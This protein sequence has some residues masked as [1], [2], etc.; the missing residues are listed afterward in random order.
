VNKG[1]DV[2][3]IA[4]GGF[5]SAGAGNATNTPTQRF[6]RMNIST[7]RIRDRD[8]SRADGLA[9]TLQDPTAEQ[10]EICIEAE[11]CFWCGA[12]HGVYGKPITGWSMHWSKAHGITAQSV[13]DILG[14]TTRRVFVADST[15]EKMRANYL[16]RDPEQIEEARQISSR[17]R[18]GKR[19]TLTKGGRAKLQRTMRATAR[20]LWHEEPELMEQAT[21]KRRATTLSKTPRMPCTVC[22]KPTKSPATAD[23]ATVRQSCSAACQA[24]LLRRRRVVSD[25]DVPEIRRRVD[26]GERHRDIAADFGC[27][28]RLISKIGQRE[29]R[30]HVPEELAHRSIY[31]TGELHLGPLNE[32]RHCRPTRSNTDDE[33]I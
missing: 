20:R 9:A 21:E 2:L 24:E 12:T 19:S 14:C 10:L 5:G 4:R 28:R 6:G 26:A 31:V 33:I 18:K 27:S 16:Q 7:K 29:T 11:I 1:E 22:G 23:R 15:R 30:G 8:K 13:R 3:D 25:E 17:K 32:C